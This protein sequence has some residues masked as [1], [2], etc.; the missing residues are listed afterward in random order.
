MKA[1]RASNFSKVNQ[2]SNKDTFRNPIL[3]VT[4]ESNKRDKKALTILKHLTQEFLKGPGEN[5]QVLREELN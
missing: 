5:F 2:P 4:F 3:R 1:S